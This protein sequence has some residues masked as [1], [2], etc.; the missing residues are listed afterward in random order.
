VIFTRSGFFLAKI[1]AYGAGVFRI[2]SIY[3]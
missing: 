3:Q 2:F 1:P